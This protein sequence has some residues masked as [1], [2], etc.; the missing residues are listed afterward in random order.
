MKPRILYQLTSP[1][2]RTLGVEEIERRRVYL[3]EAA[4]SD[5]VIDVWPLADGPSAVE[6]N[7][8]AALVVPELLRAVPK[9]IAE[10]YDAVVIGCFSDPGIAAIRDLADIPVIGPG[11][12]AMHLAAQFGERFAVLSSDPTPKGLPA[13]LR[14]LG[15]ADLFVS[16]RMVGCSVL[17]LVRRPDEAFNGILAAARACVDDGADILVMGCTGMGFTPRLTERLQDRVGVPV[18]NSVLA[19]LK[20]AEAAVRLNLR[21]AKI[22]GSNR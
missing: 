22:S 21:P 6:S 5:V 14:S 11:G 12:S 20:I 2:H 16:E 10:S 3:S 19:G 4:A 13:R 1:M 8:D 9:W 15:L 18:V 17:D 7:A